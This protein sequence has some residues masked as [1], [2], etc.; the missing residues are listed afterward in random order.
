M[1]QEES[2]ADALYRGLRKAEEEIVTLR[3]RCEAARL[4]THD[5]LARAYPRVFRHFHSQSETFGYG[6]DRNREGY[7]ATPFHERGFEHPAGWTALVARLAQTLENLMTV[8]GG[9]INCAQCKSKFGGLRFYACYSEDVPAELTLRA[10]AAIAAAE[11]ESYYTCE[12]CGAQGDRKCDH[13]WVYVEC[14]DCAARH[15]VN[16]AVADLDVRMP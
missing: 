2:E 10:D 15:L 6:V 11:N 7:V 16:E 4:L 1:S 12:M 14:P 8:H 5:E 13:G 3:A 9:E